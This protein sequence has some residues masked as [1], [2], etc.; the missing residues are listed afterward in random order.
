MDP[1]V[2]VLLYLYR[3][4]IKT[5]SRVSEEEEDEED[6]RRDQSESIARP[7]RRG[8]TAALARFVLEFAFESQSQSI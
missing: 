7:Q 3:T 6:G 2:F 4:K 8:R 5:K 1:L